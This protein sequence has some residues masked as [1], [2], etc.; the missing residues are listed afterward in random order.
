MPL[1]YRL[2]MLSCLHVVVLLLY[3]RTELARAFCLRAYEM[4][5]T[6]KHLYT[7]WPLVMAAMGE[8]DKARVRGWALRSCCCFGQTEGMWD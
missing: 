6:D 4:E 1:T 8:K 5:R 7:V 2:Y 3:V